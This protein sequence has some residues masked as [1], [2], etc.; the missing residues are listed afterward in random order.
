MV[1]E[2]SNSIGLPTLASTAD[3]SIF[4]GELQ[5]DERVLWAGRPA[6][7]HLLGAND[8]YLIPLS[9]LWGGFAIFWEVVVLTQRNEQGARV[10]WFFA[11][12]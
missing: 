8:W 3:P 1:S 10:P 4:R 2:L 5:G 12:W 6:A 7:G 9:L 11:V